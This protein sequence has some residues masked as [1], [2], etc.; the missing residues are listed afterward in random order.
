MLLLKH[1]G[2]SRMTSHF[3][4]ITFKFKRRSSKIDP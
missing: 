3:S 4:Q 2:E 1:Y